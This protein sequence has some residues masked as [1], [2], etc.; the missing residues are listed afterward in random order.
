MASW[1]ERK[2]I[3]FQQQRELEAQ[4]R[5]DRE[6]QE[7]WRGS[8]PSKDD[9]EWTDKWGTEWCRLPSGG[10]SWVKKENMSREAWKLFDEMKRTM[11]QHASEHQRREQDLAWFQ[12]KDDPPCSAPSLA[13]TG[14]QHQDLQ[15][16][17]QGVIPVDLESDAA[18][19]LCSHKLAR[20]IIAFVLLI[21][22]FC[23]RF[24][25]CLCVCSFALRV[26][27]R[28]ELAAGRSRWRSLFS[29]SSLGQMLFCSRLHL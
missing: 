20:Y 24:V 14:G 28:P 12:R 26:S 1:A 6:L 25:L 19:A 10:N 22:T 17:P 23:F 11:Q 2:A 4:E 18:P 8:F 13:T 15:P 27:S 29:R 7:W 3:A 16:P 5:R 21:L 9:V